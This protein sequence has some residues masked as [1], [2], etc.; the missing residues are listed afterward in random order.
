MEDEEPP[1][2][3]LPPLLLL[4]PQPGRVATAR[5][6]PNKSFQR[7]GIKISLVSETLFHGIDL[8]RLGARRFMF[9]SSDLAPA[10]HYTGGNPEVVLSPLEQF[11]ADVISLNQ[12]NVEVAAKRHVHPPPTR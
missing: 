9:C 4:L 5:S 11:R 12:P 8:R 6:I 1:L 7:I 3:P 2:P 10:V